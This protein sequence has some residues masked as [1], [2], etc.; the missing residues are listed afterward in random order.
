MIF[1]CVFLHKILQKVHNKIL[2][3]LL[4]LCKIKTTKSR[5]EMFVLALET[6][7]K[8]LDA[9]KYA[10]DNELI[11]KENASRIIEEAKEKATLIL[12]NAKNEAKEKTQ[13][14]ISEAEKKADE[15]LL[16]AENKAKEEASNIKES[17]SEKLSDASS[18]IINQII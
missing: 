17:L 2:T 14:I 4:T 7:N 1:I 15:I 18:F 3:Y 8:I 11:A 9:E 6:V 13:E 5:K 16:S 12:E 10:K